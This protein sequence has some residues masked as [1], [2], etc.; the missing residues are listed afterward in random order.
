MA[1]L[2]KMAQVH[3]I[4]TLWRQ[5]WSCRR[6]ARELGIYRDTVRKYVDQFKAA[7]SKPATEV[8]PGISGD[9][10]PDPKPAKEGCRKPPDPAGFSV[11]ASSDN[12]SLMLHS[13]PLPP[14]EPPKS[15]ERPSP[16]HPPGSQSWGI[17]PGR[18]AFERLMP[19]RR[20]GKSPRLQLRARRLRGNQVPGSTIHGAPIAGHPHPCPCRREAS[21]LSCPRS[22]CFMPDEN[23]RFIRRRQQRPRP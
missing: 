2:L 13:A 1:N 11:P 19:H 17:I 3:T 21:F 20:G 18:R 22:G 14:P 7:K 5:G 6:I 12:A 15:P 8:T 9:P 23:G 4:E 10:P 16:P